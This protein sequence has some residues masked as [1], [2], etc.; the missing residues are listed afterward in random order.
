MA[1][2]PG[3]WTL[4]VDNDKTRVNDD[5]LRRMRHIHQTESAFLQVWKGEPVGFEDGETSDPFERAHRIALGVLELALPSPPD[6]DMVTFI[7]SAAHALAYVIIANR[8]SDNLKDVSEKVYTRD[9]Y[10]RD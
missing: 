1:L 10:G 9:I 5:F 4:I 8:R 2:L 3:P 6:E 7:A